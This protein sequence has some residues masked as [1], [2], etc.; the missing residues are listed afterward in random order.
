MLI[1]QPHV[2]LNYLQYCR[3]NKRTNVEIEMPADF[4]NALLLDNGRRILW[5]L[6]RT[7]YEPYARFSYES[8]YL[9]IRYMMISNDPKYTVSSEA[10]FRTVLQKAGAKGE[11]RLRILM[12]EKLGHELMKNS[13][14]KLNRL[15]KAAHV[16]F[17]RYSFYEEIGMVLYTSLNISHEQKPVQKTVVPVPP[18]RPEIKRVEKDPGKAPQSLDIPVLSTLKD[19]A[20]WVTKQADALAPRIRFKCPPALQNSLL[21]GAKNNDGSPM[22]RIISMLKSAGVFISPCHYG[23]GGFDIEVVKY[24]PG[25]HIIRAIYLGR[26]NELSDREKQTWL[27]AKK[28]LS[29]IHATKPADK[30]LAIYRAIGQR[31][32][33]TIDESTDED[34]C[35]IGPLLNGQANCDGY[36]DAFYLCAALAGITVGYVRGCSNLSE[37]KVPEFAHETHLWNT[38]CI[39]N[40]W[41]MLDATWDHNNA[42]DSLSYTFFMIG[43]DRAKIAYR[44]NEDICPHL[45]ETTDPHRAS[46]IYDFMCSNRSEALAAFRK[47]KKLK[48]EV[49]YIFPSC[50]GVLDGAS[51]VLAYISRTG[52]NQAWHS[53]YPDFRSW[54]IIIKT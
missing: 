47:M 49:F 9:K 39:D 26:E 21:D 45:Q 8:G 6:S 51:D 20:D 28:L 22:P 30:A 44:W 24:F 19:V 32:V 41:T 12:S 34:D 42:G 54:R 2:F 35:A 29:D 10:E 11:Q 36:A 4:A 53:E 5:A 43:N 48:N 25:F 13:R 18:P 33:Y 40:K 7:D 27:A 1:S 16:I 52:I 37:H 14:E 38:I 50:K 15:E 23:P 46:V 3:T 17:S 31:T